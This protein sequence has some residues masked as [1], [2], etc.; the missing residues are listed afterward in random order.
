MS[1]HNVGPITLSIAS[2]GTDSPALSAQ[3]SA[4]QRKVLFGSSVQFVVAA[5]AALTGAITIQVLMEESGSSWKTLQA[6][7][8]TDIT[9]A[10][11]KALV[12]NAGAFRDLRI[13]SSASEAAQRDFKLTFQVTVTL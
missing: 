9:V 10:A 6:P 13:H 7:D 12:V 11:D 4:G 3:L 1:A 5:P 8:E 2:S